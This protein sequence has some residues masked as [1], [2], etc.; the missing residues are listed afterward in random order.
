MLVFIPLRHPKK[1]SNQTLKIMIK[2]LT[3]MFPP[4]RETGYKKTLVE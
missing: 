2:K 4:H 1:T 3:N